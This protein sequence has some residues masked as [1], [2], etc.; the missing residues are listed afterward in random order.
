MKREPNPYEAPRESISSCPPSN[1]RHEFYLTIQYLWLG[2]LLYSPLAL[3]SIS[4]PNRALCAF[5][6]LATASVPAAATC[7]YFALFVRCKSKP[8]RN[9]PN[10]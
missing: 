3:A 5:V 9:R 8:E 4:G 7:V 6:F 10:R 2:T 1:F